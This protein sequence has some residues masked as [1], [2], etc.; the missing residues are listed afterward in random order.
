MANLTILCRLK[1]DTP[2][3]D[4]TRLPIW[5]LIPHTTSK[6]LMDPRILVDSMPKP[7]SG[8]ANKI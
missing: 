5:S 1:I 6:L 4:Y 2:K 3:Y 8:I 7:N